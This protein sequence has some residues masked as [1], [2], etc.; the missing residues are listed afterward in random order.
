MI[1]TLGAI[2]L[3]EGPLLSPLFGNEFC[4]LLFLGLISLLFFC[5][6]HLISN[7]LYLHALGCKGKY[8]Q[9]LHFF[10]SLFLYALYFLDHDHSHQVSSILMASSIKREKFLY[11]EVLTSDNSLEEHR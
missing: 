7:N 11:T 6:S 4:L 8:K 2:K 5:R 9:H 3:P 1:L 10:V